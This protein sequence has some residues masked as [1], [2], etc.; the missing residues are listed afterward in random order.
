VISAS[1]A[2]WNICDIAD[3]FSIFKVCSQVCFPAGICDLRLGQLVSLWVGYHANKNFA[4]RDKLQTGFSR[5]SLF[6]A[7]CGLLL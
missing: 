7:G 2:K 6:G 1:T 4:F 3:G 5:S